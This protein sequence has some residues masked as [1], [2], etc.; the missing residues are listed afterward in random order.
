MKAHRIRQI[1]FFFLKL[2]KKK[3]K[4]YNRLLKQLGVGIFLSPTVSTTRVL[5]DTHESVPG[6]QNWNESVTIGDVDEDEVD[7]CESLILN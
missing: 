2:K 3:K 5:L 1:F 6:Y 7:T 4:G